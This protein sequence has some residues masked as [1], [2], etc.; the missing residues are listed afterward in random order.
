MPLQKS[1]RKGV[2]YNRKDPMQ[3]P[4]LQIVKHHEE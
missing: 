1:V 3:T 2:R 4:K